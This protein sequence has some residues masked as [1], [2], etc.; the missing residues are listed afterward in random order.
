M[1]FCE[2]QVLQ[3]WWF[4]DLLM[5]TFDL[6]WDMALSILLQ[7]SLDSPGRKQMAHGIRTTETNPFLFAETRHPFPCIYRELKMNPNRLHLSL[8]HFEYSG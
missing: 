7:A 6:L 5:I 8:Q 1:F 3:K 4:S 2:W